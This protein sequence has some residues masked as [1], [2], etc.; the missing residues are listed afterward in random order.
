[1]GE[2]NVLAH[3]GL[4]IASGSRATRTEKLRATT[5]KRFSCLG[6]ASA[7]FS[8]MLSQRCP[9]RRASTTTSSRPR[10]ISTA[11]VLLS[12]LIAM[13]FVSPMSIA[14]ISDCQ[15]LYVGRVWVESGTGLYQAVFLNNPSDSLGS[16]WVRFTGWTAD[17]KKSALALLTTAK[18]SGH[19]VQ[20]VTTET[21]G[22]GIQSAQTTAKS[23][24]LASSP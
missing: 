9:A 17:D 21:N 15:D 7:F 11:T 5:M 19:R 4:Q 14:D 18:I 23:L 3:H 10:A 13:L 16:Y 12:A 8:V 20:L 1:M 22:C 6:V 24:I 2:R